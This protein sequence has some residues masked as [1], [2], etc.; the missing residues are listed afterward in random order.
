MYRWPLS[1][2]LGFDIGRWNNVTYISQVPTHL[3]LAIKPD[4]MLSRVLL[5][6]HEFAQYLHG[7]AVAGFGCAGEL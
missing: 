5:L 4:V 3:H 7:V 1:R 2:E 6:T